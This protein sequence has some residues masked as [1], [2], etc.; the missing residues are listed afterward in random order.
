M[1]IAVEE[2]AG[3]QQMVL[4]G[5]F[6]TADQIIAMSKDAKGIG[7]DAV[8][9]GHSNHFY[10]RTTKDIADYTRGV[11]DAIDLGV[12][13]FIAGHWNFGRIDAAGYPME[14]I[15]Y[16]A[17]VE[18]VIAVKYEVGQPGA[19]GTYE[20]FEALQDVNV[21]PSLPDWAAFIAKRPRAVA[22]QMIG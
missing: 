9:L 5:T 8:L 22:R 6:D 17:E 7:V 14:T 13:L 11:C 15:L 16:L 3:Q 12:V 20:C 4:H 10:P 2:A 21:E 18:N 1:E 19:V